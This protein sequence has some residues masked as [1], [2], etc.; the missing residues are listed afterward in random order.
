ML[1]NCVMWWSSEVIIY[2]WTPQSLLHA[3]ELRNS[4][5]WHI[6][7][8][9]NSRELLHISICGCI[10]HRQT[11]FQKVLSQFSYGRRPSM[12]TTGGTRRYVFVEFVILTRHLKIRWLKHYHTLKFLTLSILISAKCVH[13]RLHAKIGRLCKHPAAW[14]HWHEATFNRNKKNVIQYSKLHHHVSHVEVFRVRAQSQIPIPFN[15]TSHPPSPAWKSLL[16]G[17]H[18]RPG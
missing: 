8:V 11:S 2:A 7:K 5:N 13:T 9:I 6:K 17:G 15:F 4:D 1:N 18:S 12:A 3:D 14:Y 10:Y 16:P